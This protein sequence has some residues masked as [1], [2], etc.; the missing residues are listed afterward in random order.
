MQT[1]NDKV[2]E[3]ALEMLEENKVA[4]KK[5]MCENYIKLINKL[6]DAVENFVDALV[7]SIASESVE[8]E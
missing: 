7:E 3:L 5:E 8:K 1:V 6:P 4:I 2:R